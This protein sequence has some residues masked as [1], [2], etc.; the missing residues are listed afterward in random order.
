MKDSSAPVEQPP[1]ATVWTGPGGMLR[2]ARERKG[3]SI[4]PVADA[5]HLSTDVVEALEAERFDDLPP[6]T[7]VRG[8]L[9]AYAH[10]VEV[11]EDRLM[12]AFDR[13]GLEEPAPLVGAAPGAS[14]PRRAPPLTVALLAV[15]MAVAAGL[16]WWWFDGRV[17]AEPDAGPEPGASAPAVDAE[18]ASDAPGRG[19][20]E[21]QRVAASK[22]VMDPPP[23]SAGPEPST[24]E[25]EQVAAPMDALADSGSVTDAPSDGE[26]DVPAPEPGLTAET[27]PFGGGAEEPALDP[28][29]PSAGQPAETADAAAGTAAEPAAMADGQGVA[30]GG[31]PATLTLSFNDES[32]VD[33]RDANGQRLLYGLISPPAQRTVAGQPPFTLVIGA[34]P[35]V[36]MRYQGQAVP[37]APHTRGDVARFQWPPDS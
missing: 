25:S 10:L 18:G 37:L 14:R 24:D 8:Y 6:L 4:R 5:L 29:G 32:W 3:L 33:I 2:D 26:A 9:R 17:P 1:A 15:V 30:E 22:T 21:G 35:S 34:A 36:R 16:G 28:P 20:D 31:A 19:M 27:D 7:F 12:A 11:P 23:V 13:L